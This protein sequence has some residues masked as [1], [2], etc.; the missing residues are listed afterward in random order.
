MAESPG[1]APER[2]VMLATKL[3]MPASRPGLVPRPR[4]TVCLD[5]GLAR[6]LVL[7]CAPAGYGKTV[8]LAD[9]ARRGGHPAGWLSLDA[10]DNDPARFWHHAVAALDR[11]RPGTG[12]RV[13]PLLGPPAPSS[14][15]G[16]VTA[17]INDLA[18]EEALLVLDD[19]HLI[20]AR[21][22]HE[23]LAFL[24]EH[25]PAGLCVVLA[26][27]SDPPLPLARLRARNQLTE[28]RAAELRFTPAEAG[29]LLQHA[30]AALP[31]ASVAALAVRTEGWAVGLQLAAL[32]LRGHDDAAAFVAA[33]TGS[34]R[35]VLDY[36][37]E[38]VLEG[39]DTQLRTFLL[40]TSVLERLSGPLCDAATGRQGSQALLEEAERAGLFLIP[41]DEVRGW[42]R[43]HHLFADLLHARLQQEQPGRLA[44]LHRNAAAWCQEHGLA[45]EAIGH[46]AAAGEMLWAARIIEQQFDLVH[47]IRGEAA[48][49]DRWLSVLPAEVVRTRPRLLLAQAHVAGDSGHPEVME[50]LLDAAEC[51]P[52]GWADE[53]FEPASGAA[54]SF[55]IN[56]PAMTTLNRSYLAQLHGDAE[57]TAAFATQ[58]LAESKPEEGALSATAHGFLAVAEWLRGRLTEAERALA[59]SLTGW[60]ETGQLTLIGW[61]CYEL[62]LIQLAQGQLD[63]AALTCEQ[64]LGS[65]VRSGRPAPAAGPSYAGLAEIAYQRDELDVAL[66]HAT[67]GIALCRQF[68]YTPPL[69]GG[70][71]T[72]AMIRQATGDPAGA[73]EAISEAGQAAPGPAGLLN[74]VPARRARLLLAQGDLPAA[75][76]FPQENGLGPDDEPDYARESGHLVLARILLAQD[77]AGQ[78][79]ALLDRLQPAAAAQDR[80]GSLIETGAL[81]ALALA[82]AGDEAAAVTALAGA[83]LLACPQGHV[84]VFADEGPLMAA[85]LGRLIAAQRTGQAAAGVPLGYLAR[86]QRAFG[87]GQP[88]RDSVPS[89]IVDPLTSR[90]LEVLGLL[91]A[92]RSNQAIAGQLVVTLNTVKKHVGHVLGKL[93]ATNRTEAVARARE[94]GLIP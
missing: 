37:A 14:F 79:L 94:L 73:L 41:L 85:L 62:V 89:G 17:L 86:L 39:Q 40:E 34:H 25:R 33:F 78:A 1:E 47:R 87:P 80:V 20:S 57:A 10:G 55:L 30:A 35:Y 70:L 69:A 60:R 81:R 12:E 93:G 7:A 38:E 9:W 54:A 46:A 5:E 27:R 42:W 77:R 76:R 21:Q 15:Q 63:A 56:V 92:G 59:S 19:Y 24:V 91:A 65:L 4:L 64:A 72:L 44:Q 52:P 28:I 84:R 82:A 6:G 68:V 22:V 8:L 88:A 49:I 66:R 13:A 31:D 50:P 18:G 2:D 23:S 90:E 16:L 45:D 3:H 71:A 36:L 58:T 51:A 11:A 43:Y 74:P 61:G 67:E 29:E 75:A 48:T 32:S 26:S 83:L 53:P